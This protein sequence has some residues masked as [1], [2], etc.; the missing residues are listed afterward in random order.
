MRDDTGKISGILVFELNWLGDI[1]FS[2]PLLRVL[3]KSF[4]EARITCAVVKRYA[5]LLE[6]NPWVHS[7]VVVPERMGILSLPRI[8]GFVRR[9]R[10][11]NY[12]MCFF[13]KPSRTKGMMAAAAGIPVRI[14]HSGKKASLTMSVEVPSGTAHRADQILA[15][16]GALG[17]EKADGTYEYFLSPGDRSE[18]D[19]I[20]TRAGSAGNLRRVAL[21]PGGNWAA[22]RWP[23]ER[24]VE[25]GSMILD[26]FND[27]EIVVTGSP[28]DRCLANSVAGRIGTE[29]CF[30]AAGKTGMNSLAAVFAGCVLAV[31]ADSGPLHLASAVGVPTIGIFGPTSPEI[32]GQRGRGMN[33]VIRKPVDCH[34]PC[35]VETCDKENVCM[36]AIEARDVFKAAAKILSGENK[37]K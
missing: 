7:V 37:S 17:V 5:E 19:R 9:I 28:A 18:A 32:T 10:K 6:R 34:V 29:R 23:E 16:A 13:L 22:K 20:L 3:S 12:D 2:F 36:K 30:S 24:F 15:L 26:A 14:G 27:V 1:I 21:N 25:L 33:V 8:V 11:E 4:P 31:S 35:Y